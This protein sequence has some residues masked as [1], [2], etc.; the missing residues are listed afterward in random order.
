MILFDF[1]A[2]QLMRNA[3]E[4][5]ATVVRFWAGREPSC[6]GLITYCS[7]IISRYLGLGNRVILTP[8]GLY[9]TLIAAGGEVVYCWRDENERKTQTVEAV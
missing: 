3:G 2:E 6:G 5:K 4:V 8:Y 1:E 7:N 9:R